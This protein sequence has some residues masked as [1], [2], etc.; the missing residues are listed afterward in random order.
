MGELR[1]EALHRA[2]LIFIS[3]RG[4]SRQHTLSVCHPQQSH[5][6]PFL[7]KNLALFLYQGREGNLSAPVACLQLATG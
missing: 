3:L 6:K 7:I 5:V 1:F 4:N 2:R